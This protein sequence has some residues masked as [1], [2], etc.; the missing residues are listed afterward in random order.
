MHGWKIAVLCGVLIV[1]CGKSKE[2]LQAEALQK[3][4]AV[5]KEVVKAQLKDPESA[6]F[7]AVVISDSG[8]QAC[9]LWNAKNSMGG[10]GDWQV[11]WLHNKDSKWNVSIL[12]L[13]DGLLFQCADPAFKLWVAESEASKK[14]EESARSQAENKAYAIIQNAKKTSLEEA[15][16]ISKSTC[17][18]L[19]EYFIYKSEDI[20]NPARK[21]YHAL[22]EQRLRE[23]QAD[24]EQL[25]CE[26]YTDKYLGEQKYA[27]CV[28]ESKINPSLPEGTCAL[29]KQN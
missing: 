3:T 10:Y 14:S 11:A 2:E 29:F 22:P 25:N 16:K 23:S 18:N 5:V 7:K 9:A 1:G 13:R 8:E 24:L 17:A 21:P 27:D 19:V 12:D 6:Q 15:I 4:S 26:K 28:V 20:A